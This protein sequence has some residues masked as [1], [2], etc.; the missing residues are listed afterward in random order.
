MRRS[1]Q[2][3]FLFSALV[4][5]T[6]CAASGGGQPDAAE[7]SGDGVSVQVSND[8]SPPASVVIWAVTENGMR[9]RL[10]PVPPNGRRS[11][12]YDPQFRDQLVHLIAVPEGPSTGTMAQATERSSNRFSIV[13]VKTV[14]WTVSRQNVQ[15]GR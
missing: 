9:R 13:D 7:P 8:I 14:S 5:L 12:N 3:V 11:F 2:I 6:G 15:I 10:G 4:G 1:I